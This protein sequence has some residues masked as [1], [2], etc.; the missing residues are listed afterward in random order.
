[1]SALPEFT[2]DIFIVE[3]LSAQASWS[4]FKQMTREISLDEVHELLAN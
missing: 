2:E 3:Q 4:L 1:M